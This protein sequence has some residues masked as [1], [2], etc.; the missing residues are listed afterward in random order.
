MS[1]RDR[2]VTCEHEIMACT[3]VLEM[4]DRDRYVTCEHE[5]MACR[6]VLK[7]SDRDCLTTNLDHI[8]F[9]NVSWHS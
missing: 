7:M 4:S 5:T 3:S 1:D 6:S 8:L 9:S 2:Y